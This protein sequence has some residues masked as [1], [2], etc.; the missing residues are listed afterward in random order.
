MKDSELDKLLR[1]VQPPERSPE[2]KVAFPQQVIRQLFRPGH[3]QT[4]IVVPKP[5]FPLWALGFA[6]ACL[7]I[8][9]LVGRF[10]GPPVQPPGAAVSTPD[11]AKVFKEVAALFPD[12]LRGVVVRG[13]ELELVLADQPERLTAN[14]LL[15]EICQDG[16]CRTVITFSG[17]KLEVDGR[18][19]EV[20]TGTDDR[21][22]VLTDNQLW[23]SQNPGE[24][25]DGFRINA[26]FLHA[27]L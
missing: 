6:T 11:Y 2:E 20:F 3:Q 15:V 25:V 23:T 17:Q 1:S 24:I 10:P 13:D 16:R 18:S 4:V 26:H 7:V 5:R 27:Q 21:V 8:G 22:I 14:P 19:I 12:R 9:F